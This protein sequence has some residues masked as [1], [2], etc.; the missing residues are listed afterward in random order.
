MADTASIAF[1]PVP[2]RRLGHSLGIN[3]IPPKHCTYSCVYCQVGPTAATELVPRAFYPVGQIVTAVSQRVTELRR[4]GQP[5]DYLTFAPDGEP[6]LDRHLGEEIRG[7]K[8]LGIPI[9]VITNG[10][11]L[12]HPEVRAGLLAADVV[13]VKVDAAT[14]TTWRAVNRPDAVLSFDTV[15]MGLHELA[16]AFEGRLLTETMLVAGVNDD[17]VELNATAQLIQTLAPDA[18]Y[19]T[20]P[21]RPPAESW[22]TSPS[23]TVLA[24]AYAIFSAYVDTVELL[25]D[26]AEGSFGAVGDLAG[27]LINIMR[28]HPMRHGELADLLA[29]EQSNWSVVDELVAAGM[30]SMVSYRG[31]RFYLVARAPREPLDVVDEADLESFPASDPPSWTLGR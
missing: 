28:V 7:L 29:R 11:L 26:V 9:A 5:I 17:E 4:T 31:D 24:R 8:S 6:T 25:G 3:N 14:E 21:T 15:V 22:V 27:E 12:W 1:G 20:A 18:A 2:S 23:D 30:I 19:L 16:A 13:S 10:S